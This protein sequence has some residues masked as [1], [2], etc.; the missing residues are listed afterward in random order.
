MFMTNKLYPVK[1]NYHLRLR[2]MFSHQ[3]D[4]VWPDFYDLTYS[5]KCLPLRITP[6]TRE[7]IWGVGEKS[8]LKVC[9]VLWTDFLNHPHATNISTG[10]TEQS[11]THRLHQDC[12][13]AVPF[14]SFVSSVN[15]VAVRGVETLHKIF[16]GDLNHFLVQSAL[17]LWVKS[18]SQESFPVC[19]F[20]LTL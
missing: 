6:R 12:V 11:L 16:T 17:L 9:K 18:A 7:A 13:S 1:Q 10:L 4:H 14:Y 15:A 3:V 20:T 2:T 5:E 8:D 19:R